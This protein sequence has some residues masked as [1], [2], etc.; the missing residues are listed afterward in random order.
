MFFLC[1]LLSDPI[2]DLLWLD[3]FNVLFALGVGVK[4]LAARSCSRWPLCEETGATPRQTLLSAARSK[5]DPSQ[6]T[7]EPIRQDGGT[8]DKKYLRKNQIP[9][10]Q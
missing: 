10:R 5:K 9:H 6:D 4:V 1:K 2:Y 3:I 8:F 7:A